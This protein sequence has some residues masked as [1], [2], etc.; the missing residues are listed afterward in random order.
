LQFSRGCPTG[1]I[2]LSDKFCNKNEVCSPQIELEEGA[3]NMEERHE[4]VFAAKVGEEVGKMA[5][6]ATVSVEM[7]IMMK[8][9][10]MICNQSQSQPK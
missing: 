1:A 10:K 9:K 5:R 3:Q 2:I 7:K 4:L 8:L 6:V